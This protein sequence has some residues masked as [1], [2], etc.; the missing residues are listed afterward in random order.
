VVRRRLIFIVTV[1][2]SPLPKWR[3][4]KG[5]QPSIKDVAQALRSVLQ[6]SGVDPASDVF[7]R[8]TVKSAG[9]QASSPVSVLPRLARSG[10]RASTGTLLAETSRKR[11]KAPRGAGR[12][13][14]RISATKLAEELADMV[15]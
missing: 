2:P 11:P 4:G 12:R 7:S 6:E 15:Y 8:P 5:T 13:S 3:G 14:A 10:S 1:T 9:K